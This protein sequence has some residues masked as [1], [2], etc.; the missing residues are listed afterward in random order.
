MRLLYALTASLLLSACEAAGGAPHVDGSWVA[1]SFTAAPV[2]VLGAVWAAGFARGRSQRGFTASAPKASPE[3]P[4]RLLCTGLT[5]RADDQLRVV[6]VQGVLEGLP[7]D[8]SRPWPRRLVTELITDAQAQSCPPL[9]Q[10]M[11]VRSSVIRR[12]VRLV[13]EA[14][15]N[16]LELHAEPVY[17]QRGHFE[18]YIGRL[19]LAP[20]EPGRLD[21][22]PPEGPAAFSY[23]LSHDLRAPLRVVE[24]FARMLKEDYGAGLDR[25]G[26]DHLDRV[27]NAAHRMNRMIDAMLTV[28]RLHTQPLSL[29]A[30]DL[31]RLAGLIVDELRRQEPGRQVQVELQSG[32]CARGDPVLLGQLM[33]NL[34]GNAWKYTQRTEPARIV[35]ACEAGADG[36]PVYLVRDNGAGF[37]MQGVDR[38][39]GLFQRLHSSSEFPGTGVGLASVRQIVQRHGGRVWAESAPGQGAT[40]RF[41]LGE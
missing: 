13:A 41:T 1:W 15:V 40:F 26:Q 37:D 24:G 21:P 30:V 8:L 22:P 18:G 7:A 9:E 17:D 33:Q 32:L 35:V 38:L 16:G 29:E 10:L 27:L 2:L 14:S 6:E 36:Q 4:W 3:G 39:F 28:A 23:T 25:V 12:R 20:P 11:S 19:C 34:I 5:W 31:S